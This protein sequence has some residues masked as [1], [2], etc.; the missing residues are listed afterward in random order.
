MKMPMPTAMPEPPKPSGPGKRRLKPGV[1]V[2][3]RISMF[4][5]EETGE[6]LALLRYNGMISVATSDD[7][8][9]AYDECFQFYLRNCADGIRNSEAVG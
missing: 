8:D 2:N 3:P 5:S 9:K 7:R 6:H 4:R 1:T